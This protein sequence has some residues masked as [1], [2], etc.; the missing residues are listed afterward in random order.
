MNTISRR[1]PDDQGEKEQVEKPVQE[2]LPLLLQRVTDK[3]QS[4]LW[5]DLIAT[6]R[7]R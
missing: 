1:L 5:N 6:S 4:L 2:L 7:K 3:K